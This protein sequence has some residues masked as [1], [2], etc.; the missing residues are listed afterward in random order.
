MRFWINKVTNFKTTVIGKRV[1]PNK[2]VNFTF[3]G[4]KTRKRELKFLTKQPTIQF[5]TSYPI[6]CFNGMLLIY[7]ATKS[8]HVEILSTKRAKKLRQTLLIAV[9]LLSASLQIQICTNTNQTKITTNSK[10]SQRKTL[11]LRPIAEKPHIHHSEQ[12]NFSRTFSETKRKIIS[13]PKI[14]LK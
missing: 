12:P 2:N 13:P 10:K 6:F 9:K 11:N 1:K 3:H 14:K 8:N 4:K 7:M 5:Q